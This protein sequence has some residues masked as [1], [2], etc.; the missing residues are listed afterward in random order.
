M[1]IR[2]L[3]KRE[4]ACLSA[5]WELVFKRFHQNPVI[6]ITSLAEKVSQGS[7]FALITNDWAGVCTITAQWQKIV[8][9]ANGECS[10]F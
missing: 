10:F 7:L 6:E 9:T 8:P 2:V 1:L 5:D 3:D 4:D